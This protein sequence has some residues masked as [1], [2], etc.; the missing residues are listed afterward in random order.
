MVADD[1][2]AFDVAIPEFTLSMPRVPAL[3]RPAVAHCR[4]LSF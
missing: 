1:G 4:G 3:T 2:T